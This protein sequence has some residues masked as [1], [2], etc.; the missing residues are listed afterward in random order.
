MCR[1]CLFHRDLC[2]PFTFVTV[3]ESEMTFHLPRPADSAPRMDRI[4]DGAGSRFP[5]RNRKVET[6]LVL[7]RKPDAQIVIGDGIVITVVE[8][9]GDKVRLGIEAPREVSVHRREV[10]EALRRA[11]SGQAVNSDMPANDQG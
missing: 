8:I 7:S 1:I 2:I 5:R 3:A 4:L 11:N 10:V 6:M 9:R